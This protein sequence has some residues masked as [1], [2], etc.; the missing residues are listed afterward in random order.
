[1]SKQGEM[2][3][4]Q[5][6]QKI[7]EEEAIK[8]AKEHALNRYKRMTIKQKVEH[9]HNRIE[10]YL[11][12]ADEVKNLNH[13]NFINEIKYQLEDITNKEES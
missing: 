10:Q 1:M 2:I 8:A 12:L 13:I 11:A 4:K 3:H 6:E 9:I 5:I 7:A